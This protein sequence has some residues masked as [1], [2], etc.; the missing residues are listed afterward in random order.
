MAVKEIVKAK[1]DSYSSRERTAV[2]AVAVEEKDNI[3]FSVNEA[4]EGC[5]TIPSGEEGFSGD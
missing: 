5:L 1:K 4:L 3:L 2:V